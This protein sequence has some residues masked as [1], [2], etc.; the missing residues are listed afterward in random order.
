VSR[1]DTSMS[2]E[3][4]VEQDVGLDDSSEFGVDA[5]ASGGNGLRSTL[6]NQSVF[7]HFRCPET[8]LDF[9]TNGRMSS[10]AGYFRFGSETVCY[11]RASGGTRR[12]VSE[13]LHDAL[14]D[15]VVDDCAV[16]LGFNPNEII[17]NLRFERYVENR[18]SNE[19]LRKVYYLLRPFTSLSV[20]KQI[21]RFNARN[22]QDSRFPHWPV[23]T[24]VEKVCETLL[25][26]SM[27][28]K[29]V[30]RVPFVWF[31]PR[32]ARGC[33][34]MTHDVE[35]QA[36]MDFC[37]QLMNIND[38]F[39]V[40]ASFQIVPEDRYKVSSDIIATIRDR[41]FEVGIQDLN[42][43]GRLFNDK[44]EFLRRVAI[45]NQYARQY[46][47]N[48]FRAAVLYRRPDWYDSLNFSYDMSIPNV[49]HFDPQRG[50]CCSVMP[51]FIGKILELP[52]TTVQDYTLFHILNQ[53]S[54]DLWKTQIDLILKKNG[55]VSFIVHTDYITDPEA[56][57]VYESL[58]NYLKDL[59]SCEDI[60]L[61]L[62]SEI[63]NWWRTRSRLCVE[64]R[65]GTWR[66]VGEGAEHAT[67]AY[68]N[69]V[70]GRLVYN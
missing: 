60:W 36:G 31:W 45:I 14:N 67:L 12:S 15:V 20:R 54:I 5:F 4:I 44:N 16:A 2:T 25:L 48:G 13:N 55:L 38:S 37:D 42:H 46:E 22:W 39:G 3:Q 63:D 27:Q 56:R 59:R 61:A 53:Y 24:T 19:I 65:G 57:S 41:G 7:E 69:N 70:D 34:T 18:R 9:V 30:A 1:C 40:K 33:V 32:G 50:G 35:S 6:F 10:K 17:D 62:P 23:D 26:L 66:I 58:L 21:Q 52:V 43:D 29:G 49:A 8:V 28:A 11:G 64:S 51:Y 68:A 47:A